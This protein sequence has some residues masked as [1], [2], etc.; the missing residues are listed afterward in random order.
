[1]TYTLD[2]EGWPLTIHNDRG[3]VM[4]EIHCQE[5]KGP[6]QQ[7]ATE[8]RYFALHLLNLLNGATP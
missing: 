5:S 8:A 6:G 2:D 1:M 4:L 7:S 3:T